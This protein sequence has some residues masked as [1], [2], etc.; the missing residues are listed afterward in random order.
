[1]PIY[2]IGT[3]VVTESGSE[4][5]TLSEMRNWMRLDPTD[6]SDDALIGSLISAARQHIE[7]LASITIVNKTYS[8][9][10]EVSGVNHKQWIIRLPYGPLVSVTTVK[11]QDGINSFTDLTLNSDY[12]VYDNKLL[13]YRQGIFKV[14]YVTGFGSVPFD[15]KNDIMTLV[16]WMYENRG[17]MMNVDNK[18]KASQYPFWEGLNYHQYKNVLI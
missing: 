9:S 4:P 14:Q 3:K 15:L 5:V 6:T 8:T 17:K 10:F 1:M 2:T 7:N 18:A 16:A 12:E 13:L 11:Y